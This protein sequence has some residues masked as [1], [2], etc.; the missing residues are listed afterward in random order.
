MDGTRDDTVGW[1]PKEKNKGSRN[2]IREEEKEYKGL[3]H[4]DLC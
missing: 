4:T 3:H 1:G 2:H